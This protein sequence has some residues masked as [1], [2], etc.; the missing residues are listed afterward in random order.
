MGFGVIG[1]GRCNLHHQQHGSICS[2]RT[3]TGEHLFLSCTSATHQL[4]FRADVFQIPQQRQ[5]LSVSG[6][7]KT[8]DNDKNLRLHFEHKQMHFGHTQIL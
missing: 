5:A 4:R 3:N 7:G 8:N 2:G 6:N 1:A